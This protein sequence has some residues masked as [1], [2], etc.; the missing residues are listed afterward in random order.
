MPGTRRVFEIHPPRRSRGLPQTLPLATLPY[1]ILRHLSRPRG[2]ARRLAL[3]RSG[4]AAPRRGREGTPVG[5]TLAWGVRKVLLNCLSVSP[6]PSIFP[7]R[8]PCRALPVG[9]NTLRPRAEDNALARR[10]RRER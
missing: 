5:G 1:P 3:G 7:Y 4:G 10:E 2:A 9:T 8:P 6:S